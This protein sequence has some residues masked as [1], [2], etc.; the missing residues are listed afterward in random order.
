M[1]YYLLSEHQVPSEKG[2]TLKGKNW[3]QFFSIT[4][5]PFQKGAKK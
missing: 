4:V 1:I 5:D 2:S 3:S